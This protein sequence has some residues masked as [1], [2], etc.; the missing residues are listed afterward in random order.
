[1]P[2]FAKLPERVGGRRLLCL[3]RV[4]GSGFRVWA[5]S[6]ED[7]KSFGKAAAFNM[8]PGKSQTERHKRSWLEKLEKD[9]RD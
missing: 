1:M 5:L 2:V 8:A 6:L 9:A 4:E 3:R 7:S